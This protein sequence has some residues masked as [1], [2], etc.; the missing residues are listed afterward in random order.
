MSNT[1]ML[2]NENGPT[3]R[4]IDIPHFNSPLE[5]TTWV[6]RQLR[7]IGSSFSSIATAKKVS[8]N[9]VANAMHIPSDSLEKAIAGE[10]GVTQEALFSER[11]DSEGLR[12][13]AVKNKPMTRARNVKSSR[14]A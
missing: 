6:Q 10:L 7:L 2:I 13:H 11:F 4:M 8:R 5:R 12:L 3:D 9:A 1:N 14:A